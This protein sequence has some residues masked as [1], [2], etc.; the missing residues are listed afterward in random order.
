MDRLYLT[1]AVRTCIQPTGGYR[2]NSMSR[3]FAILLIGISAC[4]TG[5]K[6]SMVS[7]DEAPV[8]PEIEALT[9]ALEIAPRQIK[10][11]PTAQKLSLIHI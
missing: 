10:Q 8:D 6:P 3:L 5:C 4:I 9:R 2:L 7:I 11:E 1:D